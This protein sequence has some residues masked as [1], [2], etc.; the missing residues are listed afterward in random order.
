MKTYRRV[1]QNLSPST[2]DEIKKP[3]YE[4]VVVK[5]LEKDF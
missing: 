3:I 2:A 1:D 4:C 5:F